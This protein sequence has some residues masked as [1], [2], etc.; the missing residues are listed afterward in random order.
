MEQERFVF[1][2]IPETEN[3][4]LLRFPLES[5]TYSV[6]RSASCRITVPSGSL[7]RLH[8]RLAVSEEGVEVE[9]VGSLNGTFLEGKQV[10]SRT[11][12]LPGQQLRFGDLEARIVVARETEPDPSCWI[13]QVS[14]PGKGRVFHVTSFPALIGRTSTADICLDHPTVSRSHASLRGRKSG[15]AWVLQDLDSANGI[16]VNEVEVS[17]SLLEGGEKVR[18]GDLDLLFFGADPPPLRKSRWVLI[19]LLLLLMAGAVGYLVLDLIDTA[20]V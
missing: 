4:R 5:G 17:Q 18:V 10:E 8:A 12:V 9:D 2:V 11:P 1:E 15:S 13:R 14:G 20:S 3:D 19:L 7:S 6:G 16:A